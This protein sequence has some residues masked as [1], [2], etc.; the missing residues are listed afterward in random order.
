M[1][2]MGEPLLNFEP[3]IASLQLMMDDNAYGLS[4]RRVT[5][6]TSGVLPALDRLGDAIDVS[7]AVS[8]HAPNDELRDKLVPLNRK[9]PIAK[10]LQECRN[11]L[12][13]KDT[14]RKHITWEYVMLDKVNDSD[15][16][17]H[18]LAKI[19]KGIP[20]KINLICLLYTSPSPRDS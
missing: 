19:L 11:F 13:K 2:G 4:R 10:L 16:H 12:D 6:S 14:Q 15:E 9:Y 1:M 20:S 18:Q 17:A 7:L 5:V 8:L 3:L